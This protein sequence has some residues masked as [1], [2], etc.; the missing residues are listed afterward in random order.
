MRTP[1]SSHI[2][3]DIAAERRT[4]GDGQTAGLY[5]PNETSTRLNVHAGT[6]I[7]VAR[8]LPG[9]Y[10]RERL[11]VRFHYPV[12]SDRY[13]LA[14]GECAADGPIDHHC[15]VTRELA[16]DDESRSH[17]TACHITSL[18]ALTFQLWLGRS[19]E[20]TW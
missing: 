17:Y 14:R 20:P 19:R 4:I 11:K 15:F 2:H 7:D 6:G 5:V 10:H 13:G 16:F 8:H 18:F 3:V 12:A 1:C 9:H